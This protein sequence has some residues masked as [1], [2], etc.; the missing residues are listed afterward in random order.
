MLLPVLVA[1]VYFNTY[2]IMAVVMEMVTV[3]MLTHILMAVAMEM[4]TMV[5][6]TYTLKAVVMETVTR[7]RTFTV[8]AWFSVDTELTAA[9]IELQTLVLIWNGAINST[10]IQH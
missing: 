8:I 10:S 2:T 7:S 4:V 6:L 5:I 3:V 1:C 9:S